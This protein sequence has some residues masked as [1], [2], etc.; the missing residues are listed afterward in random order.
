MRGTRA[1]VSRWRICRSSGLRV[2]TP[3]PFE[4]L[5]TVLALT[6]SRHWSPIYSRLLQYQAAGH[7]VGL[8]TPIVTLR[9]ATTG[10]SGRNLDNRISYNL[11]CDPSNNN[12]S[13]PSSHACIF[14]SVT[15]ARNVVQNLQEPT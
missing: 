10:T 9:S 2:F 11:T 12:L 6:N 1:T 5:G 15:S 4:Y 14:S 8:T 3:S 7:D 13:S